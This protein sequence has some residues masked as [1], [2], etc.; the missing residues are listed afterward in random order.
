MK[1]DF[2]YLKTI[3]KILWYYKRVPNIYNSIRFPVQNTD[4][5]KS[6]CP[7]GLFYFYK[8]DLTIILMQKAINRKI[9]SFNFFIRTNFFGK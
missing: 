2:H 7:K 4:I 6:S 3:N 5:K 1:I 8:T 9:F